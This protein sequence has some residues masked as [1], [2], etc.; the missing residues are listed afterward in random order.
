MNIYEKWLH[1]KELVKSETEKL[2]EIEAEIWLAAEA[3]GNLN[4]KGGKTFETENGFKVTI[5]HVE[6]VKVDQKLAALRPDLFR[7]KYEFSKSE[8]KNL[9]DTQKSFVDD[10]ITI[11]MNK[12]SFKVEMV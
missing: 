2:H 7:V 4:P 6:S 1:H 10:A 9:V 3:A 11:S 12:P 5:N 8:Y